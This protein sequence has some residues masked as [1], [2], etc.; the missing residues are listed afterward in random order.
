MVGVNTR[1]EIERATIY[2]RSLIR[3]I[4]G[5]IDNFLLTFDGMR[6]K[7]RYGIAC[8]PYQEKHGASRQS[9]VFYYIQPTGTAILDVF[10]SW[11]SNLRLK[12]VSVFS[13]G[14]VL[15]PVDATEIFDVF[16]RNYLE[17]HTYIVFNNLSRAGK[18]AIEYESYV[19]SLNGRNISSS[20]LLLVIGK[21]DFI[22]YAISKAYEINRV[23][24][25]HLW[26]SSGLPEINVAFGILG[27]LEKVEKAFNSTFFIQSSIETT[28]E[29]PNEVDPNIVREYENNL[30]K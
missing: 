19:D 22:A 9:G 13:D 11:I 10:S 7:H 21:P 30:K 24:D 29:L 28:F 20:R 14:S 12:N 6:Q 26:I 15:S 2:I 16:R 3:N 5:G 4:V 25:E 1:Q 8:S 17:V 23:N 27:S 18:P